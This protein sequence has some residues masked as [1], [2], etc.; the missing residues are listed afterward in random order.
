M[1]KTKRQMNTESDRYGGYDIVSA[2]ADYL[3]EPSI[4]EEDSDANILLSD[5]GTEEQSIVRTQDAVNAQAEQA[6]TTTAAPAKPR[7]E[8][9]K[10]PEKKKTERSLEDLM[11]SIK[12]RAYMS[13]NAVTEQE[14]EVIEAEEQEVAHRARARI[15]VS[16]RT[17][18]AAFVYLAIAIALAVAVIS[19]GVSISQT[20]ATIDALTASIAQKQALLA[21]GEAELASKLDEDV[22]RQAAADLGMVPAQDPS[23][24]VPSVEK[25]E[26]PTPEPHTNAFDRFCDWLSGIL[27]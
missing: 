6:A 1:V 25:S 20:N 18:V 19:V 24:D 11:P 15:E 17:K 16:K 22:I 2:P 12:T 27:M 4:V 13:D 7:T 5:R 3:T 21:E 23:I 10:R 14:E 9:P 8:L 26:Y